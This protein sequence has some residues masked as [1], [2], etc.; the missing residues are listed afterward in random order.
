MAFGSNDFPLGPNGSFPRQRI[1]SAGNEIAPPEMMEKMYEESGLAKLPVVE[2]DYHSSVAVPFKAKGKAFGVLTLY[3]TET[4]FFNEE[5]CK[6]LQ[7]IGDDISF[8]L[9]AM[10]SET[11]RKKFEIPL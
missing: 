2:R 6:M 8:A 9:D 10:A 1:R 11:E 7:K 5:E 3:A 4:G